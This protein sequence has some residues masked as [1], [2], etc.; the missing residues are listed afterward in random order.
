MF[1]AFKFPPKFS[2]AWPTQ[3]SIVIEFQTSFD[4]QQKF[5]LEAKRKKYGGFGY[6]SRFIY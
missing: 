5:Q 1:I 2:V 6:N 3:H 4:S